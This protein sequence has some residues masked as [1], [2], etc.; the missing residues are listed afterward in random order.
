MHDFIAYLNG[1][2]SSLS[3]T[4]LD[5]SINGHLCI[6]AAEES[7]KSGQMVSVDSLRK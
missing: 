2:R 6:F 7:R 5:D 4:K 1:D 3:I